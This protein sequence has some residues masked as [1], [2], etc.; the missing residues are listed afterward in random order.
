MSKEVRGRLAWEKHKLHAVRAG[1]SAYD[2]EICRGHARNGVHH[3]HIFGLRSSYSIISKMRHH[4]C[5]ACLN[6][7]N[8][9]PPKDEDINSSRYYNDDAFGFVFLTGG[10]LSQD[11]DFVITFGSLSAIAA[12]WTY[13][14]VIDQDNTRTLALVAIPTIIVTPFIT[15]IHQHGSSYLEPPMPIEIGVCLLSVIWAFVNA[16]NENKSLER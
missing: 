2:D 10:V 6:N 15:S 11:V 12:L 9:S 1:V 3:R 14:K 5:N 7:S 16:T 4:G 13:L 8:K